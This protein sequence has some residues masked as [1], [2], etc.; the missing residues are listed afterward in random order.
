MEHGHRE[1]AA[2][3]FRRWGSFSGGFRKKKKKR[4][5][6][7]EKYL[8]VFRLKTRRGARAQTLLPPISECT[9]AQTTYT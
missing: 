2:S 5:G 4:F 7:V 1:L 9:L 8:T 6:K 3:G